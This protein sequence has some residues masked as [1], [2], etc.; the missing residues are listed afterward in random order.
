MLNVLTEK[1]V[2]E[3]TARPA[4][5]ETTRMKVWLEER[6]ARGRKVRIPKW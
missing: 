1:Q 4:S 6:I 2:E 5:T 3:F